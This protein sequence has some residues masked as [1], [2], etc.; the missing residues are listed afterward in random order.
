A[1]IGELRA[2]AL[3][4]DE[5]RDSCPSTDGHG[6]GDQELASGRPV[7]L[8]LVVGGSHPSA[9][10]RHRLCVVAG[11]LQEIT[12]LCMDCLD[13]PGGE[14]GSPPRPPDEIGGRGGSAV[15]SSPSLLFL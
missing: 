13:L 8:G 14:L 6:A 12:E 15:G 3:R 2:V 11:L 4:Q 7:A 10:S 5:T 1:G 9:R